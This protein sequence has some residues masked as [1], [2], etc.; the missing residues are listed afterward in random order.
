MPMTTKQPMIQAPS[1]V[2]QQPQLEALR[3][4]RSA[5]TDQLLSETMRRD[6][7]NQQLVHASGPAAAELHAQINIVDASVKATTNALARVDDA[8]NRAVTAGLPASYTT[9]TSALDARL[10]QFE[11]VAV[12][13]GTVGAVGLVAI[14]VMLI[15]SFR[16]RRPTRGISA[17]D[18]MRLD[19]LQRAVDV[20]AVEVERISES[21][22]F[23][24]RHTAGEKRVA[25]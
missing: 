14:I 15:Q 7:L 8:V 9:E 21:Q 11:R 25:E 18:S 13:V 12:K 19:Q 3:S 4:Q 23:M 20:I 16:R 2:A 10:A 24:A 17:E 22:R 5:L 1:A 6:Y